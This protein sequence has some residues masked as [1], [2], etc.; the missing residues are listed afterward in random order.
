VS[1]VVTWI[2]VAAVIVAVIVL[3][4]AVMPLFSRLS[5]LRR[6]AVGLQRRRDEAME[7]QAAAAELEQSLV[8]LQERAEQA[9]RRLAVIK[10][11]LGAD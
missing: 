10:A 11:G 7:L 3:V 6:A 2:V 5:A 8:A 4:A 9:R 1:T